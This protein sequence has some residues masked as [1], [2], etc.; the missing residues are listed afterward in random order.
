MAYIS[1]DEYAK[2][3]GVSR[4]AVTRAMN[5]GKKLIGISSYSKV[6]RDWFLTEMQPGCK[7]NSKK[8]L[9]ILK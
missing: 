3:R 4:V 2:K 5:K 6:G 9:V 8:G 1:V 7:N